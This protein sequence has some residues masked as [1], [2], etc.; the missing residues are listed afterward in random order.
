[1]TADSAGK[2]KI[3]LAY[4]GGLDTT[5]ALRWLID[6]YQAEVIAFCANLGQPDS[7]Q[8]VERKAR[9]GGATRVYIEDL[10][11]EYLRDYVFP[12]LQA[13]AL[14]EG[15]YTMAA[16]LGRP[17]IAKRLAEIAL[18]EGACGVAHGSTGKG[19]D[20][21]RFYSGVVAHAPHL[22]VIAPCI[23][24]ELKSRDDE[25]GYAL[26]HGLE[27]TRKADDVFSMDGSIWGTSTECGVLEDPAVAPPPHAF[28]ITR[29]V[30]E[31]PDQA[32]R[33]AITFEKGIP[34]ALDGQP[35]ESVELVLQLGC[36]GGEHGIGRVDIVENS[37]LGIKTRAIYESPAG[38]ILHR[39]HRELEALTLER[40]VLHYKSSLS[41]R[42]AELVYYGQWFSALKS[43]LDA[44]VIHTQE[45]VTGT[46]E[47]ELYK[48][49][50]T[51]SG[52]QARRSLYH[53]A[54]S[55]HDERDVFD[56]R[57]AVGFS[58]IASMPQRIQAMVALAMN[59]AK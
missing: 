14:Y 52:R 27:I 44:F 10:R 26:T 16:P 31:A 54:F 3:I 50:M 7:M 48:G 13:G 5:V 58:Y 1:M 19:N 53:D 47:L 45:V 32:R 30:Q 43:A 59:S 46:I 23:E 8:D 55:V 18:A 40:D 2:I 56:H 51:I 33:V 17:L 6:N 29:S 9:Q 4:S 34:I 38:T 37:L 35:L 15:Q 20:Q 25:I 36:I 22:A 39:A 11:E 24:W 21:V 28:Q 12:A 57:S 49:S 42:Y 41:Q